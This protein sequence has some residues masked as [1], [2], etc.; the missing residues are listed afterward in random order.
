[1][2]PVTVCRLPLNRHF[3]P[4]EI[5][6]ALEGTSYLFL[7]ESADGPLKTAR[8]SVIGCDPVVRFTAK[9]SVCVT[10]GPDGKHEEKGNPITILRRLLAPYCVPRESF[11]PAF[12]GG[13]VGL[14]SYDMK[15]YFEDLP[16]GYETAADVFD[17]AARFIRRVRRQYPTGEVA[18]V[19]HGHILLWMHLWVRGLPFDMETQFTVEPFPETASITTLTFHDGV[20]LPDLTYTRPY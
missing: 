3:K 6:S 4:R 8:Y 20:D 1:M 7:L 10:A 19:S 11:L 12:Y 15:N 16:P 5:L 13:A 17:R 2:T 14:F 9:H 18:A